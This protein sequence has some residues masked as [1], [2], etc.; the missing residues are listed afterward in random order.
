[1]IFVDNL[2]RIIL[3]VASRP[4][5]PSGFYNVRDH[6]TVTWE[7]YYRQVARRLGYSEDA[8]CLWPD[9]LLRPGFTHLAEW[10]L[11]YSGVYRFAKG[12]WKER[13]GPRTKSVIKA[14]LKGVPEPPGVKSNHS[15]PPRL[16]RAHWALQNTLH[17][18]PAA[19]IQRD[20]GPFELIPFPEAL[21]ATA[22]CLQFSG[23]ARP[24]SVSDPTASTTPVTA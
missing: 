22:A 1:L 18:L 13:L 24:G 20:Y 2:V 17:P 9:N 16:S 15:S 11:E 19:K 21:D 7:Q 3:A 5:G 23:F 12:L 4:N 6:E 14:A 8:V 10:A